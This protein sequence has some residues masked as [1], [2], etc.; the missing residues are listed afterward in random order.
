M[1]APS[2]LLNFIQ[3]KGSDKYDREGRKEVVAWIR[4]IA[5]LLEKDLLGP[6]FRAN[7]IPSRLVKRAR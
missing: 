1:P 2:K 7:Y 6:S 4:E 3:L 5:N